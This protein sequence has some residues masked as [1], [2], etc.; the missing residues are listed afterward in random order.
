MRLCI[1]TST[2]L[3]WHPKLCLKI[4]LNLLLVLLFNLLF[5]FMYFYFPVFTKSDIL[6]FLFDKEYE[7]A[8]VCW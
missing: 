6:K 8:W 1:L 5:S 7:F 4:W 2:Y 3:G